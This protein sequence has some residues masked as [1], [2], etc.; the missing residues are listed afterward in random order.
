MMFGPVIMGSSNQKISYSELGQKLVPSA[1][2]SVMTIALE[3][4]DVLSLAAGFTDNHSL[5]VPEVG[6]AVKDLLSRSGLPEYLQ[7]GPNQ[8]R[9][10]LRH[11]LAERLMK[12]DGVVYN[13]EDRKKVFI[14]NGSQQALFLATQVLCDAGDIIFVESPSYFVYLEMLKG[15]GIEAR[16]LPVTE[17][18]SIDFPGFEKELIGMR[19]SGEIDRVK[20]IYLVSYFSNPSG[21]S[22]SEDEKIRLAEVLQRL[23]EPIAV[24]EDAA[25]RELYFTE[26]YPARSIVSLDDF[27]GIS[28]LYLTTLTKPFATGLKIGSGFCTD[29]DWLER[30]LW[31]KGHHDFGSSNFTQA[32]LE[33]VLSDGSFD[34]HLRVIRQIYQEKMHTLHIALCDEGLETVGWEW[35][36]PL[37]GLYLWLKAPEELDTRMGSEFWEAC[38]RNGVLYVPGD[39][40]YGGVKVFDSV[41]LSFGVL[42]EKNLME[43]ARRFT[44]TAKLFSNIG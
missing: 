29:K 11:M 26:E 41:R 1:I 36:K 5:P 15:E 28:R 34:S 24:I 3:N 37:G 14:T 40:C 18:G 10:E 43:A 21:E 42:S 9:P 6:E 38:C 35:K 20:A 4:P 22:R 2:A 19:E 16:S 32:I 27:K 30:M 7:Y 44:E 25:Y 8:G 39:L 23:D 33:N 13:E 17:D 12:Q 31:L